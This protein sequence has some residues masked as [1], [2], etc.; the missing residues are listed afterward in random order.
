MGKG[1]TGTP[2]RGNLPQDVSPERLSV[3]GFASSGGARGGVLGMRGRVP[4]WGGR[5]SRQE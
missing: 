5:S 1:R 3:R 2:R 4:V